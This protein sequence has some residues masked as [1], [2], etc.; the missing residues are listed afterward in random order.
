MIGE[1]ELPKLGKFVYFASR[2]C[3]QQFIVNSSNNNILVYSFSTSKYKLQKI[4]IV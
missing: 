3:L 1:L 2:N 4:I